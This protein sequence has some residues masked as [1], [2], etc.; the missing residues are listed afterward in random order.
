MTAGMVCNE[1]LQ[2]FNTDIRVCVCVCVCVCIFSKISKPVLTSGCV[3]F[4][5]FSLEGGKGVKKAIKKVASGLVRDS[6]KTWFSELS[7]KGINKYITAKL[8][9]FGSISL[10]KDDFIL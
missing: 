10:S 2:Y 6:E 5:N 8:C 3:F 7:D 9:M 4:H 1:I